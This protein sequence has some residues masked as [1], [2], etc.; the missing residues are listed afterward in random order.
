LIPIKALIKRFLQL[1]PFEIRRKPHDLSRPQ[2]TLE[3][4]RLVLAYFIATKRNPTIVQIGACDGVTGDSIHEFVR[5]GRLR[6]F[7]VE[8]IEETFY[9][10]TKAYEGVSNVTLIRA[11]IARSDG[12]ISM[13]KVKAGATS[14]QQSWS[15]QLTSFDRGHLLRQGVASGDIEEV[16][17]PGLTLNTMLDRYGIGNIDILQSDAEGFDAEVV[18]MAL[19]LPTPPQC[20]YFED[21]HLSPRQMSEVFAGLARQHYKWTHDKL[22]T[23]AVSDHLATHWNSGS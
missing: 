21:L 1:T 7:L 19:A 4:I 22:N 15:P 11:A 8:P 6:A 3:I 5:T 10:L 16:G 9:A 18:H 12:E 13:Y 23:L 17:V 14:I 2:A 20:I